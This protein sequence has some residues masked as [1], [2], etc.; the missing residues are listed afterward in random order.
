MKDFLLKPEDLLGLRVTTRRSPSESDKNLSV[1][2]RKDVEAK[3][4]QIWGSLD[5]MEAEKSRRDALQEANREQ[6]QS[7]VQK[8]ISGKRKSKLNRF[9]NWPVRSLR[10]E[11]EK[12]ANASSSSRKV[13]MW[14]VGING[15]NCVGK[16]V[17]WLLTGS[18][19]MFSE[20]I[21]SAADTANQ[22]ILAYGIRKSESHPTEAHPYGYSN[23]QYVSSLISGVGIFCVGA[24]LSVYHGVSG[25]VEPH[26]LSESLS[27]AFGIL[28]VSF[29]SESVTLA[30][31]LKSI[32]E[33]AAENGM[34]AADYVYG[35]YDPC[36]NVVLLEDAAA[37][38]GVVIAAGAMGL[39]VKMGSMIPDAFGS[40]A[41]GGLLGAVASFMIYTNSTALVGR[42]I[43]EY[44]LADINREL[45]GD[46]MVR[47]VHDVK[48]IDMGNGIIRYKAE[49]DV[50][51]R[52]LAKYYLQSRADIK[53]IL[54]EVKSL[55]TEADLELFMLTHGENIVD[56]LGE[57][58][59]RIERNL[60]TVHPEVKHVDLEV[61]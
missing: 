45:E 32:R 46:I 15:F 8:I 20:A 29:V 58:V 51:G 31:A 24:G 1:Y 25:I 42:S 13:V 53:D 48:G 60:K 39:S 30:L 9:E 3:S 38:A 4:V 57:Q 35:G 49:V 2:W 18:H 36:V 19:A 5:A 33:S 56:C 34:S 11:A 61:L 7:I 16:M 28:G 37:V 44:K 23:M 54:T 40:I 6:L 41:I 21:H 17:A 27:I 14:A 12:K 55:E 47:Q 26:Q 22:L 10:P 50:D 59:D 52:E 43:P